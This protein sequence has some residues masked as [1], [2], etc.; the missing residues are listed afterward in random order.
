[1]ITNDAF[2]IAC[3]LSPGDYAERVREF[4]QLFAIALLESR[5]EPTRLYLSLDPRA[6]RGSDVRDLLRRERECR[7]FFS[8]TVEASPTALRV[9]AAVPV[10]ADECLDDLERMA[11]RALTSR[12]HACQTCR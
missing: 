10:G 2:E 7:P 8:F 12:V 4:R 6:A 3:T 9:E 1:M 5:R 11:T